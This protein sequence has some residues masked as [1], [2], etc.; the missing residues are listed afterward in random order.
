MS[1]YTYEIIKANDEGFLTQIQECL[2]GMSTM[3]T[4]KTANFC[5]HL[6]AFKFGLRFKS[7]IFI[8]QRILDVSAKKH[9]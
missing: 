2:R 8:L 7:D 3:E 4:T 9:Y 6:P 5:C 1:H